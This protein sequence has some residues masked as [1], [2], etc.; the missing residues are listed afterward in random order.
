V[1]D[2]FFLASA[3]TFARTI[4][5]TRLEVR[6]PRGLSI[7]LT[8]RVAPSSVVIGGACARFLGAARAAIDAPA[9]APAIV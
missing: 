9:P 5:L 7:S 4:A 8:T 3:G 1:T 6:S 2:F